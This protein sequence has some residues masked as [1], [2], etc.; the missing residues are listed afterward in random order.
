MQIERAH[1]SITFTFIL[2]S[3]LADM[4]IILYV[5]WMLFSAATVT[6]IAT[7]NYM[8]D[9]VH[10]FASSNRNNTPFPAYYDPTSGITDVPQTA[11]RNR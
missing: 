3:S 1:V 7:R 5:D 11:G 8:L 6:N 10:Q 9:Q 2:K 4:Y